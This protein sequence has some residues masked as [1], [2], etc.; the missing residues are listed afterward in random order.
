MFL[1]HYGVAFALKR[2]QPKI[3][4]GTLFLAVQLVDVLWGGFVL[5]GW[6]RMQIAPGLTPTTQIQFVYY[7]WTHGLLAG[8][9]WALIGFTIYYSWPTRDTAR[10]LQAALIIGAAILSHWFL[11]LIV[12]LPDL[13]LAGDTSTKVGLGLWR[14][15]AGS[16]LLELA[17]LFGGVAIYVL[18]KSARHPI[19]PGRL[20][21]LVVLLLVAYGASLFGPPPGS[22]G[23][24][25]VA[26]LIGYPIFAGIAAWVDQ[27]VP[28]LPAQRHATGREKAA[29]RR[30]RG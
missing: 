12:H 15:F 30:G 24:V 3:S 23:A 20:A 4:L 2:A 9:V 28:A 16:L 19:W 11:D 8:I 10:H 7:P 1:G 6:E 21:M 22:A 27:A 13:P 5:L 14:S 18:R 25:A 26:A 17:L 29:A